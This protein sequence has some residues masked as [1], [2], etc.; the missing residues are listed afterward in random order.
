MVKNKNNIPAY[1]EMFDMEALR[2]LA[3]M[4][5]YDV[6]VEEG[7]NIPKGEKTVPDGSFSDFSCNVWAL[8]K[9]NVRNGM[10][11]QK[12]IGA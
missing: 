1:S 7:G 8:F 5:F 4:A 11:L 2:E 10:E 3:K 6:V 9:E 12:S